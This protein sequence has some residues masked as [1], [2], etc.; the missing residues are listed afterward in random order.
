[1]EEIFDSEHENDNGKITRGLGHFSEPRM[2]CKRVLRH[3][4]LQSANDGAPDANG[5]VVHEQQDTNIDY[6]SKR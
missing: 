2:P 1:M 3:S 4:A 5:R 6:K